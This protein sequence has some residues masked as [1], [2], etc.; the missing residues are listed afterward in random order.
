MLPNFPIPRERL[1]EDHTWDELVLGVN[2]LTSQILEGITDC[3]W[4]SIIPILAD[5][6][7]VNIVSPKDAAWY[8]FRRTYHRNET[9]DT[10]ACAEA[11]IEIFRSKVGSID[12]EV[13]ERI[14]K[15]AERLSVVV[16]AGWWPV[17]LEKYPS[18]FRSWLQKLSYLRGGK[19]MMCSQLRLD[20]HDRAA[21]D[22]MLNEQQL[23][24][25]E[26]LPWTEMIKL[27]EIP[28]GKRM[29][30]AH[31][32]RLILSGWPRLQ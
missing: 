11:R 17:D 13:R 12:Q 1:N 29:E 6:R 32:F 9:P 30:Y 15:L 5:V 24:Y 25:G 2:G 21:F 14:R 19:G 7:D 16:C 8:H 28:E 4:D 31:W 27:G 3:F 26:L 22:I 10:L 18:S 20:D 23:W